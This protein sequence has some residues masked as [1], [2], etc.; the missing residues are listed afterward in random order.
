MYAN[1]T[2]LSREHLYS[3]SYGIENCKVRSRGPTGDKDYVQS[4]MG[5]H[6]GEHRN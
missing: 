2:G 5:A 6:R 1:Y 3:M 4:D